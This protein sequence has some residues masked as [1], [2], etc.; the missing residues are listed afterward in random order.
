MVNGNIGYALILKITVR[1]KCKITL[2]LFKVAEIY[3][4]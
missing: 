1:L 2:L 4:L 3:F